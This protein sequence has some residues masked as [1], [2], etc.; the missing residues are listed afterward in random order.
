MIPITNLS[1][2]LIQALLNILVVIPWTLKIVFQIDDFGFG[3]FVLPLVTPLSFFLLFGIASALE[4]L[5]KHSLSRKF[6]LFGHWTVILSIV[7]WTII[8]PFLWV[9]FFVLPIC[10]VFLL[11]V[12][13]GRNQKQLLVMNSIA[14][15]AQIALMTYFDFQ[16]VGLP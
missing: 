11:N 1:I 6:I 2:G 5:K 4:Y 9:T 14:L 13:N 8:M 10:M 12:K 16:I 15:L 7:L 3:F